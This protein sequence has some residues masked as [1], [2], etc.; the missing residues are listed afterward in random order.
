MLYHP[1]SWVGSVV[2]P[3]KP[4]AAAKLRLRRCTDAKAPRQ[5]PRGTGAFLPSFFRQCCS[6]QVQKLQAPGLPAG[7][8]WTN[9]AGGRQ[10]RSPETDPETLQQKRRR[11]P[12]GL[13]LFVWEQLVLIGPEVARGTGCG[14]WSGLT[15]ERPVSTGSLPSCAG[16]P[17]EHLPAGHLVC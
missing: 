7:S 12:A 5:P 11:Q 1:P 4:E 16:P 15:G 9:G 14:I 13:S 10:K 3:A 8:W 2:S 17:E 6:F